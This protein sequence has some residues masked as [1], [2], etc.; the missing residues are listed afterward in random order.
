MWTGI[1]LALDRDWWP[2]VNIWR[3]RE[4][5]MNLLGDPD[6]ERPRWKWKDNIKINHKQDGRM[7]IGSI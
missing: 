6:R 4:M 3:T 7:W 1:I 2:F 5:H